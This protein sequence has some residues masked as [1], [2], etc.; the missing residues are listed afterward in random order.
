VACTVNPP[1]FASATQTTFESNITLEGVSASSFG[2]SQNAT[3]AT[4]IASTLAMPAS[5]I[6]V[7]GITS[8]APA[9][10]H[11]LQSSAAVAFSVATSNSTQASSLRAALNATVAFSGA[12]SSSLRRSADSVLSAVTGI[13]ATAPAETAL[14][15]ASLP[16]PIGSFLNGLTQTCDQCAV[17]L[18]STSTGSITCSQCPPHYAW[19]SSATCVSCPSNSVTAPN[20]VAQCA[21]ESGYYDTLFGA[22]LTAPV[23]LACP[24]GAVCTSGF[25]GAAAGYWREGT[26]SAVFYQCRVGN[27]VEEHVLGPLNGRPSTNGTARRALLQLVS[28]ASVPANCVEGNMGPLCGLCVPEYSL[29]SGVCAPCNPNDAFANWSKGSRAGL[30]IGCAVVGV[31]II[32]FG[33][34]Q[35]LSPALER[36]A[37]AAITAAHAAQMALMSC[38]TGCARYCSKAPAKEGDDAAAQASQDDTGEEGTDVIVDASATVSNMESQVDAALDLQDELEELLEKLQSYAKIVVKCV[39]ARSCLKHRAAPSY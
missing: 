31:I 4:S 29:Q 16:C 22:S 39:S 14:V 35:S 20:N 33:L 21:C 6:T 37:A 28:N 18:V 24:L 19:A 26:L 34:F 10:R 30:L 32:A 23:C 13:A 11:L 15:L 1:G 5:A 36:M 8:V 17:G 3:L 25:V 7:I 12:L 2:A 27:C 38:A 9:G